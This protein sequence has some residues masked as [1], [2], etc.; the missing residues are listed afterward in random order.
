MIS[1]AAKTL[2]KILALKTM[3]VH[4]LSL[5]TKR[6]T[7]EKIHRSEQDEVDMH[8]S[9]VSEQWQRGSV[10][11]RKVSFEKQESV[12]RKRAGE[13]EAGRSRAGDAELHPNGEAD[14]NTLG[15]KQTNS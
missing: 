4:R 5:V 1:S 14:A 2:V 15:R 6:S 12:G 13:A 7:I 9:R 11:V 10:E 8:T 3:S